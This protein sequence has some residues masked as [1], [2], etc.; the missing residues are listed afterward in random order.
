MKWPGKRY[1]MPFKVIW[2]KQL[3]RQEIFLKK[4]G[5]IEEADKAFFCRYYSISIQH[6]CYSRLFWIFYGGMENMKKPRN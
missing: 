3:S 2:E 1:P 5:K 6:K 4:L